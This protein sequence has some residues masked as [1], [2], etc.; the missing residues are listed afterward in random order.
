MIINDTNKS[1]FSRSKIK[2]VLEEYNG[3]FVISTKDGK[4]VQENLDK[5]KND[6]NN[7]F[8]ISV[9]EPFKLSEIKADYVKPTYK[10]RKAT[11]TTFPAS[12]LNSKYYKYRSKS[13]NKYWEPVE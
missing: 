4:N 8:D 1:T 7:P 6:E 3:V 13:C 12:K 5:W 10:K 9:L 2:K 11:K